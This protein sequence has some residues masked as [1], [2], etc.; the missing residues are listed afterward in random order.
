MVLSY[1]GKP[2]V[3]KKLR[4]NNAKHLMLPLVVTLLFSVFLT[5]CRTARTINIESANQGSRVSV[6]VI[7]YTSSDFADSIDLLTEPSSYPVSSHYLI[8]E[9]LDASYKRNKIQVYQL[10]EETSRAW[11]SGK[12]QWQDRTNL[13]DQSIGIE[14]VN[15]ATCTKSGQQALPE[16]VA[17]VRA[18]EAIEDSTE[19]RE[20]S[21]EVRDEMLAN[22][23]PWPISVETEPAEICFYP[24]YSEEQIALLIELSR[25]ILKRHP[26]ISPTSVIGHADVAPDR[27][28]DPGPRFPWQRLYKAGIGAWYE[29]DTVT[30]YWQRFLAEQPSI[31][32]IQRALKTY[33]YNIEVTGEHD[34]QSRNVMRAFQMHFHPTKV[35]LQPDVETVAILFAL[36]DRYYPAEMAGICAV[37]PIARQGETGAETSAESLPGTECPGLEY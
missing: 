33:G 37:D 4:I 12:S 21:A 7:H 30:A 22:S 18:V 23:T 32:A 15:R 2:G 3:S 29:N 28:T 17:T 31:P 1:L 11:H 25:D 10:V 24:D 5:G 36:I 19:V 9:P 16:A 27:K 6:L 34:L 35:T 20:D 26:D 14:L 8:P 13:N